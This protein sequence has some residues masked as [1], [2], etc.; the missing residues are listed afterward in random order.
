M[1]VE[2]KARAALFLENVGYYRFSGYSYPFRKREIVNKEAK[3]SDDFIP[4][5][6]FET[7]IQLYLFDRR[8]RLHV[9][10]AIE[11]V[12]VSVRVRLALEM[13]TLGV[14]AHRELAH[15]EPRIANRQ[16][17]PTALTSYDLWK[18][19]LDKLELRC[20]EDFADHFRQSYPQD[21]FP[22]WISIEMWDFGL[23]SKY[24]E[25]LRI[26]D[27]HRIASH[28]GVV[29]SNIFGS[30]L[31]AINFIRNK[32]AHHARL[33]NAGVIE[34]PALP[35]KG[36]LT[37]LDHLAK[38]SRQTEKLYGTLVIIIHLMKTIC[39]DSKWLERLRTHLKSFPTV[40]P[41]SLA[42]AGFP[43]GWD[44]LDIWQ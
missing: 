21:D 43:S 41:I 33:W 44:N 23:L 4:G 29:K 36:T 25:F 3:I 17:N 34:Q 7:I 24:F 9:L 20:K 19:D 11:R 37:E 31:R 6:N 10:D 40:S 30:W 5:T 26:K 35:I 18:Q 27:A 28:Y 38:D 2:D 14:T 1:I 16:K 22:I 39:P 8:L 13:G 15:L 12:E 42:D 32:C